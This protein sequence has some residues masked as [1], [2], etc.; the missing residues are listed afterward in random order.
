MKVKSVIEKKGQEVVSVSPGM[1]LRD[2]VAVLSEKRIGAV[3]VMNETGQPIGILS[4]RDILNECNR[5]T[6]LDEMKVEEAMTKDL[7]IGLPDDDLD[8]AMNTMTTKRIRHLPIM[9]GEEVQGILSIGDVVNA[10]RRV[11]ETE[12]LYLRDYIHGKYS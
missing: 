2:A 12:I 11:R 8:Q 3:L 7:V 6:N 4:E 9:H 5:K 10:L 1:S